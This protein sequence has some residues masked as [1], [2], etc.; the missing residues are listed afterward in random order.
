M[1][2][3]R[4][5]PVDQDLEH[6][7]TAFDHEGIAFDLTCYRVVTSCSRSRNVVLK[8]PTVVLKRVNGGMVIL[9]CSRY[10]ARVIVS[11]YI[12]EFAPVVPF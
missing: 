6:D 4:G 10:D 7:G 3:S 5:V 9:F 12:K 8:G 1:Q 11:R 2:G